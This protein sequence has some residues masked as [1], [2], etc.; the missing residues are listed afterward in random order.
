L[1]AES[2]E[3]DDVVVAELKEGETTLERLDQSELR[4]WLDRYSLGSLW[5]M[6]KLEQS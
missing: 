2:I 6:G 5:T 4:L 3:P 1:N